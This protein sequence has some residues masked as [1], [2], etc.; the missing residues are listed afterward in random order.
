VERE[1]CE[2]RLG[3]KPKTEAE[4]HKPGMEADSKMNQES[5]VVV[6]QVTIQN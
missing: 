4:T 6:D 2:I 1:S 5:R 3:N